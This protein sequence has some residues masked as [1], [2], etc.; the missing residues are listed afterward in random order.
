MRILPSHAVHFRS[1]TRNTRTSS[2][3]LREIPRLRKLD[4]RCRITLPI[5]V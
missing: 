2:G 4:K 5:L 3:N 1:R